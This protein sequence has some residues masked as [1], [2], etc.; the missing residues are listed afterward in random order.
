MRALERITGLYMRQRNKEMW[1]MVA[2]LGL[3]PPWKAHCVFV[4]YGR[5]WLWSGQKSQPLILLCVWRGKA[6]WKLSVVEKAQ[7]KCSDWVCREES[8]RVALIFICWAK[9]E[10]LAS[11]SGSI[12]THF[13]RPLAWIKGHF[14]RKWGWVA[15]RLKMNSSNLWTVLL[16]LTLLKYHCL[17]S[18]RGTLSR[19]R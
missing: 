8:F 18:D 16:W 1:E 5:D 11:S 4:A 6:L 15:N 2:G 9:S 19:G 13:F 14:L 10:M 3:N 17:Q 7:S 12:D